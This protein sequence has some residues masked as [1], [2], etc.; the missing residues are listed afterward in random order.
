[1]TSAKSK[2]SETNGGT[3]ARDAGETVRVGKL[4]GFSALG[5]RA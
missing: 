5:T 3:L 2:A 1:M 4:D